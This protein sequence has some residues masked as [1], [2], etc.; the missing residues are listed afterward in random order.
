MRRLEELSG[1]FHVSESKKHPDQEGVVVILT[2]RHDEASERDIQSKIDKVEAAENFDI[3]FLGLE[4]FEGTDP[5]SAINRAIRETY[6]LVVKVDIQ[7]TVSYEKESARLQNIQNNTST[8]TTPVELVP[9][10]YYLQDT[11]FVAAGIETGA[12]YQ[13]VVGYAVIDEYYISTWSVR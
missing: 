5:N 11:R 8:A 6:R 7:N 2:E 13:S 10:G 4:N 1:K 3:Q 9:Y 12:L